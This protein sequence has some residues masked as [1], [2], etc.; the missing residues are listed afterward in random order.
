MNS[1][2]VLPWLLAI[3][4][5]IVPFAA[6]SSGGGSVSTPVRTPPQRPEDVYSYCFDDAKAAGDRVTKDGWGPTQEYTRFA[7]L[8]DGFAGS[9]LPDTDDSIADW[10][11]GP[12][13]QLT[14]KPA[15]A[16]PTSRAAFDAAF[17]AC[18]TKYGGPATPASEALRPPPDVQR[19]T[20]CVAGAAYH[21]E[22]TYG[23]GSLAYS[24]DY[25]TWVHDNIDE[26]EATDYHYIEGE[27]TQATGKSPFAQPE[28][29]TPFRTATAGC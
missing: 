11:Q 4:A 12:Y 28:A 19:K 1:R 20:I 6:C 8:L 14:G 18:N 16:N 27:Y 26:D 2:S 25:D 5:A 10:F 21:A 3:G 23:T 9:L 24:S 15:W 17:A 22:A 7:S 29:A 13:E